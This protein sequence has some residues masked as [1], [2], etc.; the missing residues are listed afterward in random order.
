M[1]LRAST[2][3]QR[4]SISF[5]AAIELDVRTPDLSLKAYLLQCCMARRLGRLETLQYLL[6]Q[7]STEAL[8]MMTTDL[9]TP[10][11]KAAEGNHLECVKL[12]LQES[13][14]GNGAQ[15]LRCTQHTL[16]VPRNCSRST[17]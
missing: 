15:H 17:C 11:S 12:L 8:Q 10:L 2:C 14:S 13:M 7:V 6:G 1:D 9:M 5:A 3:A 16:R 4:T